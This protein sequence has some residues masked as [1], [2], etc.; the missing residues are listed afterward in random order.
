[1]ANGTSPKEIDGLNQWPHFTQNKTG[2]R[3]EMLYGIGEFTMAAY[4]IND[5]KLMITAKFCGTRGWNDSKNNKTQLYDL[6]TN[7]SENHKENLAMTEEGREIVEQLKNGL[8]KY[9]CLMKPPLSG[10]GSD[11]NS[12]LP[13]DAASPKNFGGFISPGWC[14]AKQEIALDWRKGSNCTVNTKNLK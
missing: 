10:Q 11:P 7:P 2:I 5:L 12:I 8:K 6:G 4:R 9:C 14:D 13:S 1:M 3:S